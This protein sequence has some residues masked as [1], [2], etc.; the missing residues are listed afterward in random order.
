VIQV[1]WRWTKRV[2]VGAIAL[3]ATLFLAFALFIVYERHRLSKFNRTHDEPLKVDAGDPVLESAHR[4]RG[5][6]RAAPSDN[7]LQFVV[8]PSFGPRWFAVSIAEV[9][10]KGVGEAIIE[11][12][13]MGHFDRRMFEM[14][15]SD[16]HRFLGRWDALTDGYSGEGRVFTDGNPLAFERRRGNRVTSGDDWAIGLPSYFLNMSPTFRTCAT[17]GW[18]KC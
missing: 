17:S 11:T 3:I 10:G 16:L 7:S 1:I 9:N 8:M 12:R 15:A 2:V 18:K 14:P 13:D 6:L 4:L 5:M